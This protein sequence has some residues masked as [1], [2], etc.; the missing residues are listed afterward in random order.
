MFVMLRFVHRV[1]DYFWL[2]WPAYW[3][4]VLVVMDDRFHQHNPLRTDCPRHPRCNRCGRLE[5]ARGTEVRPCRFAERHRR[6]KS[7][8]CRYE[9]AFVSQP[10]DNVKGLLSDVH[11][12]FSYPAVYT[13]TVCP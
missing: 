7:R 9:N 13:I 10:S 3:T 11:F 1:L 12:D 6:E 8:G 5:R 4:G 2:F